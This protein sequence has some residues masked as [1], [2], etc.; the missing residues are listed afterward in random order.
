VKWGKDAATAA[1]TVNN[2]EERQAHRGN[3]KHMCKETAHEACMMLSMHSPRF[4]KWT[5][6]KQARASPE[7]AS[8]N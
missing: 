6:T 3:R 8:S 1:G 5:L 2:G 7:T 4:S